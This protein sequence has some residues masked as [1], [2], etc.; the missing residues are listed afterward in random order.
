MFLTPKT[1]ERAR[2]VCQRENGRLALIKS[3]YK[4]KWIMRNLKTEN[5]MPFWI[6]LHKQRGDLM[7]VDDEATY[8]VAY[9]E[10]KILGHGVLDRVGDYCYA[11]WPKSNYTFPTLAGRITGEDC[12][13]KKY[14][15]CEKDY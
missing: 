6:G 12:N 3:D 10:N 13:E 14:F 11:L 2:A 4:Y 9:V 5:G 15:I 1:F 8:R 7:W